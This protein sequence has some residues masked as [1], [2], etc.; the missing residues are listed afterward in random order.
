[1]DARGTLYDMEDL[2][3]EALKLAASVAIAVLILWAMIEMSCR[4]YPEAMA[5]RR[6]GTAGFLGFLA[7]GS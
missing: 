4:L 1:M 6:Y 3:N 5:A 7:S 2:A